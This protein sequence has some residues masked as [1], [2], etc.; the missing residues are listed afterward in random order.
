MTKIHDLNRMTALYERLS[1]DD[2]VSGDS[3]SISNQK[4][5]LEEYATKN[6]FRNVRHYTDDG[7]TGRNFNRPGFQQML[8]DIENDL[9]GTVIVKDMSRFG[10][11][12]L[13]VGFYTE[14]LFP[15]KNVRFI[16]INNSVDSNKPNDNDFTPFLNIMNEW[17]AKDTS[18]K[19]KT[20]F[21]SRMREGKRVSG[22]IP[23][24]YMRLPEDKQNLVVDPVASEVVKRI[25]DMAAHD[26]GPTEIAS[27][28]TEE[29]VLIPAA[30]TRRFHPEQSNNR[31][32]K[33]EY[34]WSSTTVS[35]MLQRQEYL[36]HTIL[37]KT[38]GTD[39]K[40][41]SRRAATEDEMFVFENTHEPIIDQETWDRVRLSRVRRP[42]KNKPGKYNW[43]NK[44]EG[45]L[46]CADCGARMALQVHENKNGTPILTYRCSR[47]GGS[48]S[49]SRECTMHYISEK[50]LDTIIGKIVRRVIW[51]ALKDEETFAR[52]LCK[53]WE[54]Q[55]NEGFKRRK[56]QLKEDERRFEELNALIQSLYQNFARGL[57]PE[58]QYRTM[59]KQYDDEQNRLEVRINEISKDI[60]TEERE[61]A[62]INRFIKIVR[63]F[64]NQKD[65]LD[66]D[67]LKELVDRID[68]HQSEEGTK[69]EPRKIT[70][71]VTFRFIGD[72][73]LDPTPEEK[74]EEKKLLQQKKKED[75]IRK[76]K[77]NEKK[78]EWRFKKA[79]ERRKEVEKTGHQYQM[80]N[81]VFCGN[82]YWPTSSTQRY[83]SDN[84]KNE[85][86]QMRNGRP[87]EKHDGHPFAQK[88]CEVC[89]NLFWPTNSKNT[90]CSDVCREIRRSMRYK[91]RLER[92]K[93]ERSRNRVPL[94]EM[95]CSYCG[96]K[97]IPKTSRQI[98]CS[99]YCAGRDWWLKNR[100]KTSGITVTEETPQSSD[101]SAA[102]DESRSQ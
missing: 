6:G 92:D 66:K 43:M 81:C 16:A 60:E 58:R 59:M 51:H 8:K 33:D 77:V 67:L 30:Y 41:D 45:L 102:H 96:K 78:K 90:L 72:C 46:F 49:L 73:L 31:P 40:T 17:Y 57:L 37:R 48:N 5:Y 74:R 26:I 44:Y 79:E 39:F 62:D 35:E 7:Y 80:R 24:G 88:K 98:Y 11:N 42:K 99:D 87:W 70:V 32:F 15:K 100:K 76:E 38:I 84:C 27:R 10:R 2:D 94:K 23:Y 56:A 85:A 65:V 93:E 25:F 54:E 101:L 12:Y 53:R 21:L 14:M 75:E 36:G 13:Q 82:E 63:D 89:G 18:N 19:I 34:K 86:Q 91:Q 64:R 52:N 47:Y 20:I 3:L 9:V 83:C 1:R 68:I 22:M 28:L 71:D 55:E 50:D 97:F 69:G 61:P 29:K 95:E 4:M